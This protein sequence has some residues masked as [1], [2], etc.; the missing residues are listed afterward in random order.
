MSSKSTGTYSCQQP[1]MCCGLSLDFFSHH[2]SSS[3]RLSSNN[4]ELTKIHANDSE[5]V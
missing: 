5:G 2:A 3:F 1:M 4:V